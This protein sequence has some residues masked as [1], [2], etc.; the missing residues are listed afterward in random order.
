LTLTEQNRRT[1]FTTNTVSNM[2]EVETRQ[3]DAEIKAVEEGILKEE[4]L[5]KTSAP[6]WH[7]FAAITI[8]VFAIIGLSLGLGV[9]LRDNDTSDN[10]IT[11]DTSNIKRNELYYENNVGPLFVKI[12]LF[13]NSPKSASK[14]ELKQAIGQAA[15]LLENNV[16]KRNL[17]ILGYENTGRPWRFYGS[18]C[19]DDMAILESDG[20]AIDS[21]SAADKTDTVS[22]YGTNNQEEYVEEGDTVQTDDGG[23]YVFAAYGDTIKIWD[24]AGTLVATE[25]MPKVESTTQD[26][27]P[28][29][30]P[31]PVNG[32]VAASTKSVQSYFCN[33]KARVESLLFASDR[34]VAVVSGYGSMS[35]KDLDGE[36]PLIYNYGETQVRMY[37]TSGV[38]NGE[39]LKFKGSRK[40]H[41]KFI[42][43]RALGDNIH[44]VTLSHIDTYT[45]LA[46]PLER[47]TWQEQDNPLQGLTDHEYAKA[48]RN[49]AEND[50]IPSFSE[51]LLSQICDDTV[52][53][54]T[55]FTAPSMFSSGASG[56]EDIV[57]GNGIIDQYAA[58]HSMNVLDIDAMP[59]YVNEEMNM[60]MNVSSAF[61]PSGSV[62]TYASE[63]VLVLGGR[64]YSF[65]PEFG[66]SVE[67]TYLLGFQF[68]SDGTTVPFGHTS[69]PG[70]L[71]SQF[72]L[73]SVGN[74]LRVASTIR[75]RWVS[76]SSTIV[77]EP[78]RRTQN[79]VVVLK[80]D[81][82]EWQTVGRTP[83][84]G[85]DG[86]VITAVRF[87]DDKAFVVTFE[88]TDPFYV[89]DMS[90]PTE[91][92]IPVLGELSITGFSRYLHPM[93]DEETILLALG[94]EADENGRTTGLQITIF[95][96]S[97]ATKPVALH[98]LESGDNAY[99]AAEFDHRAF[100]YF[101]VPGLDDADG[102]L[103]IPMTQYNW[104]GKKSDN[105]DGFVI[106]KISIE[107]GISE[108]FRISHV[109]ADSDTPECYSGNSYLSERSFV[110][111]GVVMTMK[112]HSVVNSDLGSKEF[113]SKLE[114]DASRTED[115]Y[116]WWGR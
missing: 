42:S 12:N 95:D 22:D 111:S 57:W 46:G 98:R 114:M 90:D 23:N 75:N 112:G 21:M 53:C 38:A 61:F 2:P 86:E 48:A 103:I 62:L 25:T 60:P 78:L 39:G 49:Y 66:A 54:P 35:A 15:A 32:T 91:A 107:N 51:Q 20:G 28:D 56:N 31:K 6:R 106:Y 73:D 10:N 45:T 7:T 81:A 40:V 100:R 70:Y 69:L 94:Q 44:I 79:Q 77:Q 1:V 59:D 88:Q 93:N 34:L 17:N 52:V 115:C 83:N 50:L 116:T 47:T 43:A 27:G 71:L 101:N 97:I 8:T 19:G 99:S 108:H 30:D 33:P 102:F 5:K 24:T 36:H 9:G 63:N 96:T 72:S 18:P 85:K 82:G 84:L 109:D 113:V 13:N 58:I 14:E 37:D 76:V 104:N 55:H 80:L 41:G 87:L 105:F 3:N 4:T 64:G 29:E 26:N 89:L 74:Y 65:D 110:F 16:I 11:G 92:N 67:Q 68:K